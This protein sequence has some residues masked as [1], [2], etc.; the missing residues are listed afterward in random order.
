M[1]DCSLDNQEVGVTEGFVASSCVEHVVWAAE[2]DPGSGRGLP[3]PVLHQPPTSPSTSQRISRC[4][5]ASGPG[6]G[7]AA[8]GSLPL[9]RADLPQA[10]RAGPL[11]QPQEG[12]GGAGGRWTL[13]LGKG[14]VPFHL[15]RGAGQAAAGA[16]RAEAG[17]GPRAGARTGA[18][19]LSA[20]GRDHS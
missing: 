3:G 5:E 6:H 15:Y 18:W 1:I 13:E 20:V 4:H 8:P 2:R 12:D 11:L 16:E 10:V 17:A 7:E 9:P 14:C 19:K